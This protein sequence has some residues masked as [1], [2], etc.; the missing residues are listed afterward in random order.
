MVS[1]H[2]RWFVII[3][4]QENCHEDD[5][6]NVDWKSTIPCYKSVFTMSTLQKLN[7]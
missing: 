5:D 7:D 3:L 1:A 6:D 2:W 4:Y